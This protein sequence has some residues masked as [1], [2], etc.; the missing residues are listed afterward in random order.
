MLSYIC[1]RSDAKDPWVDLTCTV[2]LC[3]QTHS[4]R[5]YKSCHAGVAA[6]SQLVLPK[7]KSRAHACLMCLAY[8]LR[9]ACDHGASCCRSLGQNFLANADILQRIADAAKLAPQHPVLEVGPGTGNLTRCLLSRGA[10]VTAIEK[11]RRL[12][13]QLSAE[14]PQASSRINWSL[15]NLA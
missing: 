12:I 2:G 8:L 3:C 11:D 7:P 5:V 15:T 9:R 10:S 6:A 1:V 14:F 13:K 4:A